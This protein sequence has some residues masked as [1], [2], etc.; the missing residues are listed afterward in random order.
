MSNLPFSLVG[1]RA[2]FPKRGRVKDHPICLDSLLIDD[3]DLHPNDLA[4]ARRM[5]RS[6][7]A[8]FE[9]ALISAHLIRPQDLLTAQSQFHQAQIVDLSQTERSV[10][11]ADLIGLRNCLTQSVV[12]IQRIGSGVLIV[13]SRPSQFSR[14]KA[15][16]PQSHHPVLMGLASDDDIHAALAQ[17]HAAQLAQMAETRVATRDSCRQWNVPRLRAGALCLLFAMCVLLYV[18]PWIVLPA[19][20]AWAILSLAATTALRLGAIA[21]Y[22]RPQPPAQDVAQVR[23]PVVSVLVPLLREREIAAHLIARLSQLT[24][25]KHLLDICLVVEN[26]DQITRA[27]LGRTRLPT[28]M[29]TIVVPQGSLKTKPRAMNYALDFCRGSIVGIYDAEDAPAHDQ[30]DQVV[31][32]F[33]Q[34]PPDVACLQGV[35]DFYNSRQ[36]WLARCF[37]IEY[38][39]WFRVV[40][41]GLRKL[42]FAVPLG[43]TTL[44]FRRQALEALGGWDA[45][46]VTEDA[47]LGMRLARRGYRTDII[48]TVTHEEANCRVWPWVKQR[49][50]WLK[51]YA[52]TYGVHMRAPRKL[53]RELGAWQFLGFQ[54]LF[55]GTLSQFILAPLLWALWLIPISSA[56]VFGDSLS[57]PFL[58]GLAGM[59]IAA[60]LIAITSNAIAVNRRGFRSLWLWIPAMHVYFW[61]GTLAVY[62]ALWEIVRCPFYWDKTSH[63]RGLQDKVTAPARPQ[64]PISAA[65]ERQLIYARA[66]HDTRH[67]RHH[68]QWQPRS[69]HAHQAF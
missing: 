19:L 27:T 21:M 37:T 4:R 3:F 42:G 65:P 26:D 57:P 10:D 59:F 43:G 44:F 52:V 23:T 30:I 64:H 51:G 17:D 48:E 54:I 2:V 49:S 6:G 45:H 35:L 8:S 18:A 41:P 32:R 50:R 29:R 55:L 31:N 7:D 9:Q 13:T 67:P 16:I 15:M 62:K 60:E 68:F 56:A 20:T 69:P 14:I 5:A 66:T 38:A 58:W 34:L 11:L 63:G 53:W 12:P 1:P 47:D 25:P 33:A 46:N 22:R 36:N 39:T 61:F 28:W 40:L 24:Y